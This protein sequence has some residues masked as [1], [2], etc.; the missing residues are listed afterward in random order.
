MFFESNPSGPRS[1]AGYVE[2]LGFVLPLG[3]QQSPEFQTWEFLGTVCG[4]LWGSFREVLWA[5]EPEAALGKN[6]E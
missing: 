1:V 5:E 6:A 3:L 2:G 4:V